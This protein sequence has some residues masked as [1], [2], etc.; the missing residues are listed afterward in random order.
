MMCWH[1]RIVFG[2]MVSL[3]AALPVLAQDPAPLTD[4][5]K[6]LLTLIEKLENRVSALEAQLAEMKQASPSPEAAS[7]PAAQV[8]AEDTA[9][10]KTD[11]KSLEERVA[12]LEKEREGSLKTF[13]KE[14]LRLESPDGQFK[15]KLG[16]RLYMDFVWFDQ[17][18]SLKR[19]FG[20][21]Q[22]GGQIRMGRI[23]LQGTLYENVLYRLEYELAGN[24]GPNGFT[25]TYLG[26]TGIPG[27]SSI[28]V[29]HFKEP[30]SLEEITSDLYTS[31]MERAMPVSIAPSRNLG[32]MASGAWLGEPK[33]E[34]LFAQV[35]TFKETDNWPSANDLDEARGWSLTARVAGLPW[36]ADKGRQ[37]LHLGASYSRR[38]IDGATV[39]PYRFQ[40]RPETALALYRYVDSEGFKGFRLQDTRPED[41]DLYGLEAALVLGPV[42]AQAE[43]LLAD[44]NTT[45]AG[46]LRFAGWYAFLS[47][48]LTGENRVYNHKDG[49]FGRLIPRHNFAWGKG[50]GAWELLARYSTLD[51]N[52]DITRGGNQDNITLGLNWYWNPNT[53]LMLDYTY[54][55]VDH[56][57]YSGNMNIVQTRFQVDF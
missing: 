44:V 31:F 15:L 35:G 11:S 26:Y 56:D 41:A 21:E 23:D 36:Y 40:P 24:N 46:D 6:E 10:G 42:S 9:T 19:A 52:A 37:L 34:R 57:L 55:D 22:D 51:L 7:A 13:W 43:Y 48:F 18:A 20:D 32:I 3:L 29:G 8:S 12:V 28:L 45:F 38:D 49:T 33:Q 27:I 39:N 14:G 5:E 16:G 47:W 53:R 54:A 4:R 25:D 30:F 2:A 17:D 50:W 1:T